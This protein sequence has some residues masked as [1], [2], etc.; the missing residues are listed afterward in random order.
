MAL[1]GLKLVQAPKRNSPDPVTQRRLRLV[2][3]VEKQVTLVESHK[4]GRKPRG[5]WWFMDPDGKPI[6]AI[7]YGKVPLELAKGKHAIACDDMDDVIDALHKAKAATLDGTFDAQLTTIS[8]EVRSRFKKG[9]A[10]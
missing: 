9:A 2:M 10:S 6:L 3:Q 5:R 4:Q 7:K 8:A 1:E